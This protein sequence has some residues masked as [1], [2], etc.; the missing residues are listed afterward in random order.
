MSRHPLDFEYERHDG[1]RALIDGVRYCLEDV[2][3]GFDRWQEPHAQGPGLYVAVVSGPSVRAFADPMGDDRW[4]VEESRAVSEDL[5]AFCEA[6]RQVARTRDGAVVVSVDGVVAER[7]V[8]FRDPDRDRADAPPV[9]YADWMGARHMSAL[10]TSTRE[11]V[12]TTL[13]LSAE[14]GRVT[15]FRDGNYESR[16]RDALAARWHGSAEDEGDGE[17]GATS[18]TGRR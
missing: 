13:T 15:V 4:P 10:D 2:S 12:V 17:A 11:S 3:L 16:E 1:V 9:E 6:A 14:T 7:M 18:A 8:R 5:T